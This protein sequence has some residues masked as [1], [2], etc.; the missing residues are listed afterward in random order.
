MPS[1]SEHWSEGVIE[2][3][4]AVG[5]EIKLQIKKRKAAG[6]DANGGA[7]LHVRTV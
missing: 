3:A 2:I 6:G 1:V 5:L 4:G 7:S